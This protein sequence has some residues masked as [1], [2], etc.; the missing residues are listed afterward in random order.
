VNDAKH[1]GLDVYQATI[2]A[3]RCPK[4]HNFSKIANSGSPRGPEIGATQPPGQ[5]LLQTDL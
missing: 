3:L 1:I 4:H 5:A 2:S